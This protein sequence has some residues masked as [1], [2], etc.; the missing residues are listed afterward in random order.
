MGNACLSPVP[1][2][3]LGRDVRCGKCAACRGLS[4]WWKRNRIGLE[5]LGHQGDRAWFCTL[6]FSALPQEGDGYDH[7]Q[8]WLKRVRKA[9]PDLR[10]RF[11]AVREYG[12]RH[13][14]LHYHVLLFADGRVTYRSIPAWECGFSR[15][16]VADQEAWEYVVKYCQKDVGAKVR[17][18]TRLG[19][20]LVETVAGH[21]LV[22]SVLRAFSGSKLVRVGKFVVPHA[23]RPMAGSDPDHLLRRDLLEGLSESESTRG[24]SAEVWKEWMKSIPPEV[25]RKVRRTSSPTPLSPNSHLET[26]DTE[27]GEFD[28][29]GQSPENPGGPDGI[30]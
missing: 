18:S 30:E 24:I 29:R 9:H 1:N 19:V 23:M 7:V 17:G 14:R 11:I 5:V 12:P 10:I 20:E 28:N 6:T 15:Y 13:Q 25:V 2:A 21:D 16:K 26:D 8:K 4:A 3:Y 27:D 22:A